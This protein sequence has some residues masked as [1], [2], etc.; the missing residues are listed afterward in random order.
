MSKKEQPKPIVVTDAGTN[1]G[2]VRV[3]DTQNGTNIVVPNTVQDVAQAIK[4]V[5]RR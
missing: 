3:T 1:D 2:Q 4:D 5:N